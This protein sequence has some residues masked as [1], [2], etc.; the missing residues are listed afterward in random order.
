MGDIADAML[1]GSLCEGC[2]VYMGDDVGYPR[3]CSAC[4]REERKAS[5]PPAAIHAD[6]PYCGKRVKAAGLQ[7]H[8][9]AKHASDRGEKQ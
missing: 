1:D 6:C 2:G 7:M 3:K 5:A 8:V 4:S 9:D